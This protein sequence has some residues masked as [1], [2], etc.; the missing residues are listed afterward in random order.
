MAKFSDGFQRIEFSSVLELLL[1]LLPPFLLGA[2]IGKRIADRYP[3]DPAVEAAIVH[4]LDAAFFA[5]G[6]LIRS[7]LLV[8]GG[9]GG[10]T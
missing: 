10:G 3:L 9:V 7:L 6:R 4:A 8:P 5:A 1:W 2:W